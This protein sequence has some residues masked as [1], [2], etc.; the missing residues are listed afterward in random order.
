MSVSAHRFTGVG[1]DVEAGEVAAGDVDSDTV[2]GFEEVACGCEGD[3][4]WVD[5]ARGH[6]LGFGPRVAVTGAEDGVAEIEVVA[7]GVIFAW[8]VDVKE[9]GGEVSIGSS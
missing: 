9:F 1:V 2:A 8:R 5:L 6:H 3:R 7:I 4:D